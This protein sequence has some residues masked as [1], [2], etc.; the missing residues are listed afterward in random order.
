MEKGPDLD[1]SDGCGPFEILSAPKQT[2][3]ALALAMSS[4]QEVRGT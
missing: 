3:P 1:T 4:L 2:R